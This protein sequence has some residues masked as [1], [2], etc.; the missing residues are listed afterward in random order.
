LA[1]IS[2]GIFFVAA[3]RRVS[4]FGQGRTSQTDVMSTASIGS[5][6][7]QDQRPGNRAAGPFGKS[8]NGK[9]VI[10]FFKCF[11]SMWLEATSLLLFWSIPFV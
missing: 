5:D 10:I 4:L 2:H 6:I 3:P 1:I 9:V 7:G 11:T 8:D